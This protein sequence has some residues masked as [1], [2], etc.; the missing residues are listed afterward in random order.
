M[1]V[2]SAVSCATDKKYERSKPPSPQTKHRAHNCSPG[3]MNAENKDDKKEVI[4]LRSDSDN[5]DSDVVGLDADEEETLV[6]IACVD[7]VVLQAHQNDLMGSGLCRAIFDDDMEGR[8]VSVFPSKLTAKLLEYLAHHKGCP[9]AAPLMPLRAF[10]LTDICE[11]QWDAT[12]VNAVFTEEGV[13]GVT[14][15]ALAADFFQM[16]ELMKLCAARHAISR[17]TMS[18]PDFR[19]AHKDSKKS[20]KRTFDQIVAKK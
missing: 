3:S 7:N 20:R 10:E 16:D 12:F 4:D 2:E 17:A 11:D 19:Q 5:S 1:C 9:K 13:D 14:R 6:E 18:A 8:I 15:L